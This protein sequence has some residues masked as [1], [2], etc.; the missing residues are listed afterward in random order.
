MLAVDVVE[1][2]CIRVA[3]LWECLPIMLDGRWRGQ[4]RKETLIQLQKVVGRQRYNRWVGWMTVC[5]YVGMV[6]VSLR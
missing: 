6:H 2:G 1:E 4:K 5:M 3:A